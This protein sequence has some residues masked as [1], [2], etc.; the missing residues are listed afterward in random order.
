LIDRKIDYYAHMEQAKLAGTIAVT[1]V[2]ATL[3]LPQMPA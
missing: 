3:G 2:H 1:I